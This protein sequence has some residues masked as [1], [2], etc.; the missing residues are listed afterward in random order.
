MVEP[1]PITLPVPHPP[2][3]QFHTAPVPNEPP[4]TVSATLPPRQ[5]WLLAAL[6][7]APEGSVEGIH[8][9]VTVTLNVHEDDP[10]ELVAEHVTTVVP[11]A[12]VLPEAGEHD[13]EGAGVPVADGVL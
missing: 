13:T 4:D 3:Y 10:Q 6:L 9:P 5:T 8:P 12:N 11:E 1:L 2:S 7:E